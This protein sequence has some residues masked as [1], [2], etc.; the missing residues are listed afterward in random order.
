M[1]LFLI[2]KKIILTQFRRGKADPLN[3][4]VASMSSILDV[5]G[6]ETPSW[7]TTLWIQNLEIVT[8]PDVHG[9]EPIRDQKTQRHK[10][11]HPSLHLKHHRV[12]NWEEISA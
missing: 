11:D 5:D 8:V 10:G 9:T 12:K 1:P 6:M 7:N 3:E 2:A 4:V